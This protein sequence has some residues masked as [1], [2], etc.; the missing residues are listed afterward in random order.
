MATG[1]NIQAFN[2]DL[3]AVSKQL[4]IGLDKVVR[5][6]VFDIHKSVTDISPWKTG[7]FRASWGI[8][9]FEI[10]ND[11][12]E[13]DSKGAEVPISKQKSR[14]NTSVPDPLIVWYVYNNLPY[15]QK[16]EDGSS[17]QAPAGIMNLAL[18]TVEAEID[19]ILGG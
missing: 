17:Q 15:A 19:T 12:G 11:P 14:M 18:A 13:P 4:D 5:K 10:P 6:V 9:P 2:A 7:R 8:S 16:L 3:T 1:K